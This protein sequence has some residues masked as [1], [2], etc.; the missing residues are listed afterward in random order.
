MSKVSREAA[1]KR[2]RRDFANGAAERPLPHTPCKMARLNV[3]CCMLP[4]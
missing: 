3:P 4:L 2:R 1:G